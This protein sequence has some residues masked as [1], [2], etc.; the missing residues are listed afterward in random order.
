MTI[1]P[2]KC[3]KREKMKRSIRD[4]RQKLRQTRTPQVKTIDK[5]SFT[6]GVLLI[7][8]TQ[9]IL[10]TYPKKFISYYTLIFVGL[11]VWRIFDYYR[12]GHIIYL[13]GF[14]YYVNISIIL[15]AFTDPANK[16]WFD[17]NYCFASG[18]VITAIITCYKPQTLGKS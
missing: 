17:I 15:Q 8:I 14:C 10:L 2:E 7:V 5:I 12:N 16:A 13:L 4:V 3:D 6:L 9:W 1:T 18:Y 11:M